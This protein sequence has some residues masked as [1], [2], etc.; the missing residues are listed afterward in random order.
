MNYPQALHF[1]DSFLNLEKLSQFPQNPFF[2]LERMNHLLRIGGHP[3][4]NFLAILIA[5]TTGKGSTGFFL[6]SILRANKI[7]VG[8][9]HSPHIE[10]VRERIRLEGRP[11]SKKIWAKELSNIKALLLKRPLP[12]KLGTLTY[13]EILTFLAVLIFAKTNRRIGIFE[14][15]LGGR[16]D[17]TNILKAPLTILTPIHL[18]HEHFLG[19]TIGKIAKEKAAIIKKNC[20]I[21]TAPQCPEALSVIKQ[22]VRKNQARLWRAK[23]LTNT[24]IALC[25]EFQKINAGTAMKAAEIFRSEFEAPIRKENYSKAFQ[26]KDWKGRME[27]FRRSGHEYILDGAHNLI[28]VKS[29]IKSSAKGRSPWLIFGAMR[30][31]NSGAMLKMLAR[32][33]DRIIL[34]GIKNNRAKTAGEL[35]RESKSL[36]K[37]ALLAQNIEE[38]IRTM[39]LVSEANASV[40]VT[41]SFYLVGEA[42]KILTNKN[43]FF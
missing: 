39:E 3:E 43:R 11:V 41:G 40:V 13:F 10:D 37:C 18:D 6:E 33:F 38:A 9:Y 24:K 15:G 28:S 12:K 1:L 16:L 2:N 21:V 36:F 26:M 31:K 7:P 25:G 32:H 8:Y 17:A 34:T 35:L 23:L 30:D 42:R 4:K 29:L 5:G 19:D 22:S 14:V 20:Q 27:R